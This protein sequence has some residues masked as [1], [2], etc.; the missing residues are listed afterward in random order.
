MKVFVLLIS[1]TIATISQAESDP[2]YCYSTDTVRPQL[3]MFST[4]T[5][6]ESVRGSSVDPHVSSK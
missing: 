6:Y 1:L 3:A 5:S 2:Y 4:K